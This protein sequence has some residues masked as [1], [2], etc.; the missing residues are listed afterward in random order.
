MAGCDIGSNRPQE[1]RRRTASN[2]LAA[3]LSSCR[4]LYRQRLLMAGRGRGYRQHLCAKRAE[5]Q[6]TL[7]PS[8]QREINS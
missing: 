7:C 6:L 5:S 8:L 3:P 4:F 1:Q 2:S